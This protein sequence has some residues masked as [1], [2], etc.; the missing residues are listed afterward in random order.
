[1]LKTRSLVLL[2]LGVAVA[3]AVSLLAGRFTAPVDAVPSS[4]SAEAGFARDMQ[5]HHSQAVQMSIMVREATD[6][7]EIR[8]LAYDI[9][10]TQQQQAGQMAGWLNV[11]GLPQAAVEP[12]MTWMTRP[13]LDGESHDAHSVGNPTHKAGDPMPGVASP[14][15]MATFETLTGVEAEKY[16]VEL[17]IAHHKGAIEMARAVLDRSENRVVVELAENIIASQQSEVDYLNSLLAARE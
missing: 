5:T 10:T 7:P 11:W 1:M 15:Q 12:P 13:T 8:L 2:I 9:A 16:Y 6:D 4:T 17:M 3:I 14:E